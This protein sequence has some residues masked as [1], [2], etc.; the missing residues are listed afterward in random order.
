MTAQNP[1]GISAPD[2]FL[3]GLTGEV[4]REDV[5]KMMDI[6]QHMLIRFEK[7]N[8]MLLNFNVLSVA[9]YESVQKDFHRYTTLLIDIKK[10]LDN[11]HSRIKALKMKL[12]KQYPEAFKACS[13]VCD[14]VS[15]E[16]EDIAEKEDVTGERGIPKERDIPKEKGIPKQLPETLEPASQPSAVSADVTDTCVSAAGINGNS[17]PVAADKYTG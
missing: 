12:T 9:R 17:A 13:K 6:Q 2:E 3:R 14:V 16:D 5:Y 10:D 15:E 4:N 1:G 7:T 8:E 11:A